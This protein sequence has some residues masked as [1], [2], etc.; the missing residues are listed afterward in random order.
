MRP[1]TTTV[2]VS[3]V[4][5][6]KVAGEAAALPSASLPGVSSLSAGY[7]PEPAALPATTAVEPP[8]L[9]ALPEIADDRDAIRPGDRVLLIVEDD[10]R[11]AEVLLGIVRKQGFKGLVAL[12]GADGLDLARQYQLDAVTLDLGLPDI[13]GWQV[14]NVLKS[15]PTTRHI[16]VNIISVFE[17][18]TRGLKQGALAFLTK[19]VEEPELVQGLTELRDFIGRRVKNLLVIEDDAAQRQ[20]IVE[21]VG[22]EGVSTTAVGSG[23]DALMALRENRFDC[24]VLDLGLP[25]M[26]GLEFLDEVKRAGLRNLPII[27]YTAKDLPKS[28]ETDLKRMAQTIILKDVRSPERLLDETSLFL[29]RPANDLSEPQREVLTRLHQGAEMLIGRRILIVDDDMRNIFAVT[30]LLERHGMEVFSAET[31]TEGALHAD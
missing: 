16:P 29:H 6:L 30:S 2:E 5:T 10:P 14:L 4:K 13:D 22:N 24:V 12:R 18:P 19:P 11:F 1:V 9:P 20:S 21:L 15:D 28:E 3:A 8:S 25:D 23:R 17:D 7:A 31:G 27:V 26:T